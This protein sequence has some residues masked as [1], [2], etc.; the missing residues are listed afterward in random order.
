MPP[1][2]RLVADRRRKR[3]RREGR[4][5][6]EKRK[7]SPGEREKREKK[8]ENPECARV[9]RKSKPDYIA[10]GFF[11]KTREITDLPFFI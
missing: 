4:K 10:F 9:F 3:E 8:K 1:G 11:G 7:R 6:E 2:P 5:K